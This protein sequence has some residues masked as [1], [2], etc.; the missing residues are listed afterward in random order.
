MPIRIKN[1]IFA[2]KCENDLEEAIKVASRSAECYIKN[3]PIQ[4]NLSKR[5]YNNNYKSNHINIKNKDNHTNY[6]KQIKEKVGNWSNKKPEEQNNKF[7]SQNTNKNRNIRPRRC[8]ICKKTGHI[9]AQCKYKQ[10]IVLTLCFKTQI[11]MWK[12]LKSATWLG[13]IHLNGEE[14]LCVIILLQ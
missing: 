13:F 4:S 8:Y 12:K 14:F 3:D 9:A 10:A 1:D 6:K 5:I 11:L 2:Q 7:G